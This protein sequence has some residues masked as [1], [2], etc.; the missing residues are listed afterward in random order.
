MWHLDGE[1]LR[2]GSHRNRIWDC[3]CSFI[4]IDDLDKRLVSVSRNVGSLS[5]LTILS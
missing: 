4:F 1:G 3:F 5:L 2:V